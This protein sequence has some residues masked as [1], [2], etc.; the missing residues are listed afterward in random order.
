MFFLKSK[1]IFAAAEAIT[2]ERRWLAR[3]T[4]GELDESR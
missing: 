1:A 3:Q 4:T 2:K